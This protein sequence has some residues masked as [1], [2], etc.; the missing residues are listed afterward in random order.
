[1]VSAGEHLV[2][3]SDERYRVGWARRRTW[4]WPRRPGYPARH[5]AGRLRA[6]VGPS[7]ARVAARPLPSSRNSCAT[8]RPRP[9]PAL[10][11]RDCRCKCSS[12][13]R[14][15]W[16][17]SAAWL[18]AFDGLGRK[19][20]QLPS[21][22]LTGNVGY[23]DSD[24]LTLKRDYEKPSAGAGL[25]FIAPLYTG[26]ALDAQVALQ[27]AQQREAV[28]HYARLALSTIGD[29]ETALAGG[30]LLSER[31]RVLDAV[32]VDQRRALELAQD[33]YRVGRRICAAS[34]SSSSVSMRRRSL[35]RV[36]SEQLSQRAGCI[37]FGAWGTVAGPFLCR[38]GPLLGAS[39]LGRPRDPPGAP[40]PETVTFFA[41]TRKVTKRSAFE[42]TSDL[43]EDPNRGPVLRCP[44]TAHQNSQ[45]RSKFDR[46][47]RD[48]CAVGHA[49]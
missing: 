2:R 33:S 43:T 25:K 31:E 19:A 22:R 13:G 8:G 14:T 48:A 44:L 17:L 10:S 1:M 4:H 5:P 40:R 3:L 39:G 49:G 47:A 38:S 20:A 24:I 11:L 23:V 42:S 16:L 36:R 35:L 45:H 30:R 37:A 18:R 29:V 6:S 32:I 7:R 27:T 34:S 12:A 28:A 46:A 26:G 9:C 15:C 41:G 21:I